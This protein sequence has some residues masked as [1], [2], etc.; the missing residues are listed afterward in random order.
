M[1]IFLATSNAQDQVAN[2]EPYQPY[3]QNRQAS[4]SPLAVDRF[5]TTFLSFSPFV[6]SLIYALGILSFINLLLSVLPNPFGMLLT[7]NPFASF[8]VGRER[9]EED[10]DLVFS[11]QTV[12]RYYKMAEQLFSALDSFA[13]KYS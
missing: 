8:R 3:I 4:V 2:S 9:D 12:E 6:T 11:E 7:L 13:E 5:D 10:D 1:L